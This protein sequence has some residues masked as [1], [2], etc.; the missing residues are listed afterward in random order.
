[1]VDMIL[2][3]LKR[4]THFVTSLVFTL[5]MG[6][7]SIAQAQIAIPSQFMELASKDQ[8]D[9]KQ[10]RQLYKDVSDL[11]LELRL[12]PT[13][14]AESVRKDLDQISEQIGTLEKESNVDSANTQKIYEQLLNAQM[15]MLPSR[16]VELRGA[17]I[18]ASLIP[19]NAEAMA[20][21]MQKL[22][23]AGF[24]AV[25]PEVFRR[26][27]ALFPNSLVDM[28]PAIKTDLLKLMTDAAQK[29]GIE[30]HPWFWMFRVLSPTV[31]RTNPLVK[32]V[33]AL[34]A[35]PLDGEAYRSPNEEIE[36]ESTSFISPASY[37]WRQLLT[38]MMLQTARKYPVQGFMMDYIRYGNNQTEDDL[39]MTRFQ[40]D[41]YRKVGAFPPVRIDALSNLS[42]E[43][44]LW[45]EEQ[46]NSM[47]KELRLGFA[48]QSPEL[49]LGGA[50]FRNEI[51]ARLTKMQHWRHWSN[52]NWI[53][54]AAPMMYTNDFRD[55]DL[56]MDWESN[57]GKRHDVLYPI[58]GGHKIMGN[59]LEL[60]NQIGI[61]QR[62]QSQGVAIFAMRNINDQML[63]DLGKGPFRVKSRIPHHNIGQSLAVQLKFTSAWLRGVDKRGAESQSLNANTRTSL[64]NLAN[65]LDIVAAP[66]ASVAKRD[67]Q[68]AGDQAVQVVKQLMQEIQDSTRSFPGN[69]RSRLI[70]QMEDA[71]ELAQIYATHIAEQD[72]GYKNSSRPPT[73]VIKEAREIPGLSIPGFNQ[74]P[75]ID[76][77][78][79]D[80]IWS[81]ATKIPE[82]YW[83]IGSS[84]PQVH[85]EVR[86]AYDQNALYL[87]YINDEP[88]TERMKSSHR[89]EAKL[90][91]EDDA[92][93][94]FLSPLE[95]QQHYYY[96]VVNPANVRY[97][98]AS[99]DMSWTQPWQSATRYFSHGWVAELGIPFKSLGVKAPD[100]KSTW[101]A[102]FCR[103][104]PQEIHDFHCWSVTFGGIHR[105]ER[106]GKVNFGPL[107]APQESPATS[108]GK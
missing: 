14:D 105:T 19:T 48:N 59:R 9:S 41:Y 72:K 81:A 56:W 44:H 94:V 2:K 10:L 70:E 57:D 85:T 34:M 22:K 26:G 87:S 43:W 21:M 37:E 38:G 103:R 63:K 97:E 1:M 32:R 11:W 106:F 64:Q 20:Q 90:L 17:L 92:V 28:D 23:A 68:L 104:R 25:F 58:I 73:D 27:Y 107:P 42:A 47:V 24:N 99:F 62:R 82:L 60:L 15:R 30:V 49:A 45:R 78:L 50:V 6:L 108:A 61:L 74:G 52:N 86:L 88:R 77:R 83:S 8:Q 7:T 79:D 53:D 35:K 3:P 46:V 18:D 13:V 71:Y 93:H 4:S 89:Q 91:N 101:K 55:L 54:Y 84:R 16:A 5:C 39:S 75:E 67:P 29:E 100:G 80:P 66:L 98:R 12:D 102:N 95:Q 33:P 69:L 76:G 65:K 96:F 51:H 36:D 31:S 40:L